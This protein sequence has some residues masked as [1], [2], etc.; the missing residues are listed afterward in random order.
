MRDKVYMFLAFV[1]AV[2]IAV[3]CIKNYDRTQDAKVFGPGTYY[4]PEARYGMTSSSS[5]FNQL[6]NRR[7]VT[8]PET[9]LF[10]TSGKLIQLNGVAGSRNLYGVNNFFVT[11][12]DLGENAKTL[13]RSNW[14]NAIGVDEAAISSKGSGGITFS[15]L[16]G[17]TDI[18]DRQ[19]GEDKCIEIIAPCAFTYDNLNTDTE[20]GGDIIIINTSGTMRGKCRITFGNVANWFC[21]GTPGKITLVANNTAQDEKPWKD[22]GD[23]HQTIIGNS[24]NAEV[25]GGSAGVVLGYASPETTIKV[26]VYNGSWEVV[27]IKEW[28][29]AVSS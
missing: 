7:S 29:Q 4:V 10:R 5:L 27:S 18:F 8:C 19:E 26:E 9:Q 17:G 20:N 13:S 15:D 11:W 28:V 23:Y 14:Y 12:S 2:I 24:K 16:L 21:A 25:N 3:I 6:I 1:G 22:H